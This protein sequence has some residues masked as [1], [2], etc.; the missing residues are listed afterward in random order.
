MFEFY[1]TSQLSLEFKIVAIRDAY[2]RIE[3][4]PGAVETEH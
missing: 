1:N 3:L 4:V 2:V